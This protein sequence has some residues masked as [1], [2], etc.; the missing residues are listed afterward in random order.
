MVGWILDFG[1]LDFGR[2]WSALDFVFPRGR[3]M[4]SVCRPVAPSPAPSL[5]AADGDH[6][7]GL[8]ITL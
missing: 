4:M 6:S 7:K 3:V 2:F 1:I 5:S 8:P